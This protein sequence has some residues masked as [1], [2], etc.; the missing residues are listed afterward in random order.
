MKHFKNCQGLMTF[1]HAVND[2]GWSIAD[3]VVI[4]T[5]NCRTGAVD[6]KA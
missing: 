1:P 5:K 4:R 2:V 3:N 6:N